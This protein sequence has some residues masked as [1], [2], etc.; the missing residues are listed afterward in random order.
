VFPHNPNG[1]VDGIAGLVNANG[2]IFG[3]MAHTEAGIY[4]SRSPDWFFMKERLRREGR[5]SSS[6]KEDDDRGN[7]LQVFKNIVDY[8]K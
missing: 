5:L 2:R 8:F 6:L 7:C 3:H 4:K 1:S